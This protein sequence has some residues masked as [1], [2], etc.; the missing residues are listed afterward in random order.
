MIRLNSLLLP[1]QCIAWTLEVL[2]LLQLV[3]ALAPITPFA[4]CRLPQQSLRVCLDV[5]QFLWP[6]MNGWYPILSILLLLDYILLQQ[7]EYIQVNCGFRFDFVF[8]CDQLKL[9]SFTA[10]VHRGFIFQIRH[11][12]GVY[13]IYCGFR[14]NFVFNC[15][16]PKY[17]LLPK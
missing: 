3:V 13:Q 14:F 5:V 8:N 1:Q 7:Q 15:D 12:L 10:T 6:R 2:P 4:A 17:L 11:H 16:Q 9:S